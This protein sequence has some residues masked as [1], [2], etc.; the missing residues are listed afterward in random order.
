MNAFA[1]TL[2]AAALLLSPNDDKELEGLLKRSAYPLGDAVK[3]AM[4]V[5]R[6]G[7]IVSIE[8]E[9][10]DGK[11]VF[12]VDIAQDRKTLEILLDAGTGELVEKT[13][14]DDDQESVADACK[15]PLGRA[16]E[17]ALE[18]V[19]GRAYAA[20]AEIEEGKPVLEVKILGDGK[21]HKVKVDAVTGAVLKVKSR[22]FEGEKK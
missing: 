12:S 9:E 2:A 14:E 7:T 15:I 11:A 8:L 6:K 22:R 3:K 20:E 18:K 5:A 16:I 17:L 10:E 1:A 19:A 13:I 4:E 21:V